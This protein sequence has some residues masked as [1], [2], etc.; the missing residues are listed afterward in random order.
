MKL[1]RH[2][3]HACYLAL[4][5]SILLLTGQAFAQDTVKPAAPPAPPVQI[6]TD[7]L[8]RRMEDL[9]T[10]L[11][12]IN[13]IT[14]RGFDTREISGDLPTIQ[15][16][17]QTV[18][19]NL[20]RY[21][22]VLNIRNLQMFQVLLADMRQQ[23]DDWRTRLFNYNKELMTMNAE[24]TAFTKDSLSKQ[25]KADTIFRNF[26][27]PEL[28]ELKSKWADAKKSTSQNQ[29]R[30][31]QLQAAVSGSYFKAIELEN[32]VKSQ[33]RIFGLRSF[34][35]EY[36]FLW[37]D[38]K[39]DTTATASLTKLT[40]QSLEGQDKIMLYY[41][42][43][44]AEYWLWM[45][46]IGAVFFF[47]INKYFRRIRKAGQQALLTPPHVKY[48]RYFPVLATIV[49][50]LN[51]A[52]LFDLNPPAIYV[53]LLQGLLLLS[54]TVLFWR[55]WTR[56]MFLCWMG[57]FV[58]YFL[59]SG[60]AAVIVPDHATRVWMV[61]LNVLAIVFGLFF[62][63]R[64]YK[65]LSVGKL[66]RRVVMVFIILNILAAIFNGY[67]RMSLSKVYGMAAIAGLLQIISLTAFMQIITEALYLQMQSSRIAGGFS[68]R[69]NFEKIQA[70]LN[71]VLSILV[72]I[73]WLMVFTS[74]LN[75]YNELY[76]LISGLIVTRRN[77]GSTSFTIGNILLFFIILVIS[78]FFQKYIGYFFGETDEEQVGEVK[79][80]SSRLVLLRLILL[81][82]GFLLAIAASG[83]PLDKITVVLGALGV[84]IG[85][86]LQNIVNN[87]VSGIILIFERPLKIGDY[88]EVASQKG[89]VKDIGIRSS[90]MVTTEGAEVIIPNGDL[91]SAKLVNWTLSSNHIRTELLFTITPSQQLSAATTI[92]LEEVQASDLIIQ[93]PVPEVLVKSL[94]DTAAALKLQVWINNVHEE[95]AFKSQLLQRV[96][97]RLKAN[98]I[99]LS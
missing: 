51:I 72:V 67:G 27:L 76:N 48:V 47:R 7:S 9:H 57:V 75:I 56:R 49:L 32:K 92:I 81:V 28:K 80:K 43:K 64:F 41:L 22:K 69:L 18:Q 14:S 44:H 55:N 87:L 26:Y 84:G 4:L 19:E 45:L 42:V 11:N 8:L 94:N 90:K 17:L 50:V 93:R 60:T 97:H 74:N 20:E 70:G 39:E 65:L 88:V 78:N 2:C 83:L 53:E 58:L 34:S 95:E 5:C 30:I 29:G 63:Y 25:I 85:L 1:V 73:I 62:Y 13:N 36:N 89:R 77:I 86:G 40:T 31:T 3:Q 15:A 99:N 96:Y 59:F 82:I 16:N 6:S 61:T 21:N 37:E 23:L 68:S 10:T 91:L 71:K 52:P 66:V 46:V 33:L 98:G 35:K 79:A 12:R 54:L 38:K 24:M